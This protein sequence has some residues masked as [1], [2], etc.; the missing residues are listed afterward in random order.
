MTCAL[1]SACGA[2]PAT[3]PRAGQRRGTVLSPRK[4]PFQSECL[5]APPLCAA[6]ASRAPQRAAGPGLGLA[7]SK[8]TPTLRSAQAR[9]C[10]LRESTPICALPGPA[11]QAL[12]EPQLA[13]SPGL[14]LTSSK[15]TPTCAVPQPG[16]AN[17]IRA[18]QPCAVPRPRL[19]LPCKPGFKRHTKQNYLVTFPP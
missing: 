11:L 15:G 12:K 2:R 5:P 19:H 7:S 8:S 4:P 16:L 9:L 3:H 1:R 14:G 10:R 6:L 17:C 13:Q 18:P